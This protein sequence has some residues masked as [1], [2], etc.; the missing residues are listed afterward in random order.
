[1]IL[2]RIA[3]AIRRQDWFTVA[4]EVVIVVLGVFLGLQVN[5][6]NNDRMERAASIGYLAAM[7]NDVT[8]S[9]ESLENTILLMESDQAARLELYQYSVNPDATLSPMERHRLLRNGLYIVRPVQ[10]NHITFETLKS[11]GKLDSIRDPELISEFQSMAMYMEEEK[12]NQADAY[13][14]AQSL[15]DPMLIGHFDMLNILRQ[16]SFAGDPDVAWVPPATAPSSPAPTLMKTLPFTNM[17]LHRANLED[18]RLR[19][20]REILAQNKRIATLIDVRQAKLGV[21]Q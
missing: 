19:I 10:I 15:S 8:S 18:Y 17:T 11:A 12:E 3:D 13:N 7:E 6:W 4:I 5:N 21:R 9:I 1:M 20:A 16:P 2:K 14:M